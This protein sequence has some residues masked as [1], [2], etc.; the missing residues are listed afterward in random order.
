VCREY[1]AL[2]TPNAALRNPVEQ[3]VSA[4]VTKVGFYRIV[5][6]RSAAS[7]RSRL[8]NSRDWT[9]ADITLTLIRQCCLLG[10]GADSKGIRGGSWFQDATFWSK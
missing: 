6:P 2:C 7:E 8:S 9:Q 5:D 1:F 10:H 4:I 3:Q